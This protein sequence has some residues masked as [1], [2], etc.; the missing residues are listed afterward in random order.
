MERS[1]CKI[2]IF[3]EHPIRRTMLEQNLEIHKDSTLNEAVAIAHKL[4]LLGKILPVE[5]CR[6]VKYDEY[7]DYIE[8]SFDGEENDPMR[9]VLCGVKQSYMFDLLLETRKP[10]EKFSV[11]KHG[12]VTVKVHVV[13]LEKEKV[14]QPTN[15]RPLLS[16]TVKDLYS[17]I[18]EKFSL[19]L[20]T[21]TVVFEGTYGELKLLNNPSKVLKDLGFFKS[22]KVF[23][24]ASSLEEGLSFEKSQLYKVLD[25]YQHTIQLCVFLPDP[26]KKPSDLESTSRYI[27]EAA[28]DAD[29]NGKGKE[30]LFSVDKRITLEKLKEIL[31]NDVQCSPEFFRV[32]RVYSNN[33]EIEYTHLS[34][35]LTN[36]ADNSKLRVK[37]GR[38]VKE[39]EHQLKMFLL[40]PA[41]KEPFK[42]ICDWI[43][44]D[45][46][47][48]KTCKE[49]LLPEICQRCGIDVPVENLRMRR[50]NWKNP[51]R[52]Y[53][54]S[55]V[56][57][58]NIQVYAS[59][60]VFLEILEGP[61]RMTSADQLSLYVR[62]WH[63]S[64]LTIDPPK[65]VV[66]EE[67]LVEY[68]KEAMSTLSGIPVENLEFCKGRGQFPC[69]AP[70]LEI[71][72]NDFG[73]TADVTSLGSS[74]LFINDDGAVVFYRDKTE[75][76][77]KI[78]EEK[79]KE[80]MKKE[81]TKQVAPERN[82]KFLEQ[83]DKLRYLEE[84]ERKRREMERSMCKIKIFCEHPIRRTMLEQ[85]LE[86]HKDST[87][88]E[89][90]A[91]A[92]KLFLL[93]KILPVEQCRIVK[94]DEYYDYIERSFD[95]EEND[96]MRKVLCGVKQSY[97]F[98]LLLETRKPHEKF[99]VYKHGGITVKVH[100]VDLEKEKVAPPTNVRP[101][102]SWTVKDLYSLIHEKFSLP[103]E[104]MRVVFEGTYSELKL[105]NN[106]SKVLK[107]LG[108]FKSNK[109]F[110]EV[111][112]LEEGLS[113][114][115]SQLYKV[116]D[117]YQH[118]IQLCVFL[119]DPSKK[120]S[121]LESTSRYIFEAAVDADKNGKGK[122]KLFSVDKRIK[123]EK[124]KEILQNDVQCS[125]EFFRVYRVYSNNQ[126]IEYT[127]L[128]DSL[129]NFA[130]NSKL[131]VKYGRAVKEGEHQLKM[132]LLTPA[133]KEISLFS[134]LIK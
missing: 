91:I 80:I 68:L 31:Q 109:V 133:E 15:V 13:D 38:A 94:Y 7:Y 74:P 45:G 101:L 30:K 43:T 118:T 117:V 23:V 63:P 114:E 120:P 27:F 5:Q 59:F 70:V 2:K 49:L 130:D 82:A 105:L 75:H 48:I 60:Q 83:H 22:N 113:F 122:E 58:E 20:E 121:D 93:G 95:G 16:W 55:Q 44:S 42:Y 127:H 125:P 71:H 92:H 33:Q 100:V 52:V 61:E 53:V 17:L 126:E 66:L 37:Y 41:E 69:D 77:M 21:M 119:P 54:D 132:F 115:K 11:Y 86:I 110:V 76:L 116:L 88:N 106:P 99:S 6:I 103:L 108:F 1:M 10:H 134:N 97:M 34:D 51:G 84:V 4:F 8:R 14:A 111:S 78:S 47:S 124:L 123:L 72:G 102:L 79:K 25:V 12:G 57:E 112:S 104:T 129:T 24:E 46:M 29:K 36:F 3:C 107:D 35:S 90:V 128:S 19:P 40:T 62:H 131:R 81:N 26:S 18:H 50:K 9:K 85:N 98:D 28:V 73:W 96:P 65:E 89:A 67:S 87:L 32:Y 56:F 64:T 39:G